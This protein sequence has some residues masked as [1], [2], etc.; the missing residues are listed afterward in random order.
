MSELSTLSPKLLWQLFEQIC[1]IPHPSHHEEKLANYILDLARK[2]NIDAERDEVGNILLRKAATKG[3]EN[4]KSV[5][6]QAHLDMV[7]Q[8]NS[9]THHDFEKDPIQPYIDGEWVKA[10]NTTLGADNGVGMASAL[11]VLFDPNVEHGPLEVLLTTSEEQGM[12]GAFD[13]K[14]NWLKSEMLINTDS[15]E[16][17][18][19]CIGCAGGVDVKCELPVTW[20]NSNANTVPYK[21]TL[22]GFKGGHSGVDIHLQRGNANKLLSR[23]LFRYAEELGLQLHSISGGSLRNA[24]PREAFALFTLPENNV[25][26]LQT[27]CDIFLSQLRTEFG[28]I[29]PN[30]AITITKEA[31]SI[32]KVLESATQ[33]RLLAWLNS[34]LNGVVRMSN[35]IPGAVE[36]SLNLGVITTDEKQVSIIYLIRSASDDAKENV[37]EEL[38]AHGELSGAKYTIENAYPGWAPNPS[39]PL[40]LSI[41]QNY[42]ELFGEL[43]KTIVMHA[44][45]ECGLFKRTYPAVEMVSIGPTIVSPHSPDE[46]VNILS[47]SRYWDLLLKVL[48]SIPNA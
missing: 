48:K 30:I 33:K 7:P 36:T 47:V 42:Q 35:D 12:E 6:L 3:M 9:D 41:Q 1:S 22:K 10:R 14:A 17:G 44:G 32:N 37:A 8:K 27:K 24:I 19:I 20:Q 23:F 40:V 25:A 46:K 5:T 26:L 18:E 38:K 43:P 4:K 28:D 39:S 11:A 31:P 34:A 29:E 13:L 45:L 15:E 21:L 2:H 16:E